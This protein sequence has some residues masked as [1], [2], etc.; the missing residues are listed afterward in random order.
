MKQND[1]IYLAL[2]VVLLFIY[3]YY[4]LSEN[5]FNTRV[6]LPGGKKLIPT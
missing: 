4:T 6:M 1:I 2:F 5:A 3:L